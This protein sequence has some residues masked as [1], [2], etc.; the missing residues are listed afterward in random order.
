MLLTCSSPLQ[1]AGGCSVSVERWR[2]RPHWWRW[3]AS[4]PV[5]ALGPVWC[6]LTLRKVSSTCGTAVKHMPMPGRWPKELQTESRRGV[7]QSWVWG[8]AAVWQWRWRRKDLSLQS[9]QRLW[10]HRTTRPTTVCCRV[11]GHD[12]TDQW[13]LDY[14]QHLELMAHLCHPQILGSTTTLPGCSIWVPAPACLRGR[15]S[16]ILPEWQRESWLCLSCRRTSTLHSS[17]VPTHFCCLVI[18]V[19]FFFLWVWYSLFLYKA[20]ARAVMK[21]PDVI[22]GPVPYFSGRTHNYIVWTVTIKH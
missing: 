15:R 11:W 16:C 8:A 17:Q 10:A 18:Y 21:G 2:Q 6:F 3:I 9:S 7:P 19:V 13:Q 14:H 12:C 20:A 4:V 5:Y 1:L 22:C